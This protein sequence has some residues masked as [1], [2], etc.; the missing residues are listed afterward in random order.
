M[1]GLEHDGPSLPAE[2]RPPGAVEHG[3]VGRRGRKTWEAP[4]WHHGAAAGRRAECTA[5][6][7]AQHR[8]GG[9]VAAVS[10]GGASDGSS[11]SAAGAGCAAGWGGVPAAAADAREAAETAQAAARWEEGARANS[12]TCNTDEVL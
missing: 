3:L 9:S 2:I 8:A 6:C 12:E 5:D 1:V 4:G 7:A 10:S 11:S